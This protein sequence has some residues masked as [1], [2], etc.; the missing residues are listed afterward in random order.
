MTFAPPAMPGVQRDPAR[1]PAHHLDHQRAVVAVAGGVQPVDRLHRDADR[2]VEAEGV[3]GGVEVVV[4]RLRDAD[5]RARRPRPAWWRRRGCPRRRSGSARRCPA[6]PAWP[7]TRSGAA[8]DAVRVGAR[9]AEHRAAAGQDARGP[10]ARSM[11]TVSPSST[12]RQPSRKPTTSSPCSPIPLRTTARI[13]ALRP[14]QSPP[15]VRMPMRMR[16]LREGA[17]GSDDV[18]RAS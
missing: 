5:A 8:L 13:T 16:F 3:V 2:G 18:G 11:G 12:P 17:S 4:D 15:P 9:G 14:G 1:V 6:A 7:C 10:R